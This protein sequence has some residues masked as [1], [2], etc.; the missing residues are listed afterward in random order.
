MMMENKQLKMN[1]IFMIIR[2]R[3]YKDVHKS[4]MSCI[5]SASIIAW[6][7][8][9]LNRD[10]LH[11]PVGVWVFSYSGVKEDGVSLPSGVATW[12][13]FVCC[14]FFFFSPTYLMDSHTNSS[15]LN[16]TCL[17]TLKTLFLGTPVRLILAY[18]A[19]VMFG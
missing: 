18:C 8:L 7:L 2:I 10:W 12:V 14:C 16:L 13:V 5:F 4:S 1:E 6:I 9:D 11:G 15:T 17:V 19:F 3:L